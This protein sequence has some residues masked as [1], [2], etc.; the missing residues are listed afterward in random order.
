MKYR[1]FGKT[2]MM[3]SVF[4]MGGMR[5]IPPRVNE[6]QMAAVV[7]RGL[8]LGINH[9]ETARGYGPSEE[10]LG[11]IMHTLPREKLY[12]TTK[13]VPQDTDEQMWRFINESLERMKIS[14]IDNFDYHGI[15][16]FE[17]LEKT[18]RPGG[19]RAAVERAVDQGM[20]RHVG[21]STHGPLEVILA[22]I[23]TGEFESVNLHYYYFN[24][25]NRPAV[26][27][28]A[29][30][31]MGVFI[32]SPADKGG[33][34]FAPPEKLAALTAPLHPLVFN[35]R[36]LLGLHPHV[37]TLSFGPSFVE[38]FEP[39]LPAFDDDGPW[40]EEEQAIL[41]RLDRQWN[42]IPADEYCAQCWS[43]LPCPE[44]IT[45]PEVLRLRNLA[46]GFDMT[47]F[48]KYRY[49]MFEVAGHWFPGN[50]ADKCT[51]CGDCLP[52]CPQKLEIPRLLRDAHTRLVT[53][54]AG[55]RISSE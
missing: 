40:R 51:D 18:L 37:H 11:K 36:W 19:C 20:I 55:Q 12:I 5:F 45:I 54:E 35:A 30:L 32:I 31:D 24:Q 17:L 33:Q 46:V 49:K 28:A 48:G 39:H 21:F 25:R 14:H 7:H 53:E 41:E 27:R 43:C 26:E 16:T 15:N 47:G 3:L 38:E 42:T 44:N 6:E 2:E 13:I 29:E 22:A 52:R 34:L 8:E 1:R 10:L 4:S 23:N 50:R 9:I